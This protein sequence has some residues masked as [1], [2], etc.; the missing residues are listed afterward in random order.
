MLQGNEKDVKPEAAPMP[1]AKGAYIQWLV[2]GPQGAENFY[3]RR[4]IIDQGGL[5]PEHS[6][7][8]EH[9]IFVLS[10]QGKAVADG[11]EAP[12]TPGDFLFVPGGQ[13]HTFINTG[14]DELTFICCVNVVK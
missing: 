1:G 7:P 8:E 13:T 11:E 6:H 10:G 5:V 12:M 3:M 9:E 14:D 4:I 2:A